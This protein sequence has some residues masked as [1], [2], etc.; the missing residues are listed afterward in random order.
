MN[1]LEY[2]K[3]QQP[4]DDFRRDEMEYEDGAEISHE[5]PRCRGG[6]V[7]VFCA[8]CCRD[9]HADGWDTCTQL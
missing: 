1:D 6:G 2:R 4:C 5:C 7:R 9:H 8:N 3:G